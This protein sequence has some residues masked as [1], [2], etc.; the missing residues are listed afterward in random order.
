MALVLNF[1][2]EFANPAEQHSVESKFEVRLKDVVM[3]WTPRT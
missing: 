2:W 3:K 1:N